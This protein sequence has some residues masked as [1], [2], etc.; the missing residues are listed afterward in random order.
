MDKNMFFMINDLIYDLYSCQSVTDLKNI[1]LPRLKLVIPCSYLTILLPTPP[2]HSAPFSPVYIPDSFAVA[3]ERYLQSL[4]E[5]QLLWN[6]YSREPKLVRESDLLPDDVRLNSHLYRECYQGFHIYDSLQYTSAYNRQ[7]L[8]V[9]TL[10]RTTDEPHFTED[11]MFFVNAIGLHFNA[12]LYRISSTDSQT[13]AFPPDASSFAAQ[14]HLTRKE[15]SIF[16]LLLLYKTNEEISDALKITINT[17]QKHIQNIFRKTN[18]TS[19][20]ELLRLF[21]EQN[22]SSHIDF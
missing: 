3:E 2:D 20:W 7:F 5:D 1:F 16:S 12:V 22:H 21:L 11:E 19:K 18:T 17:L 9:L 14:Y 13:N 15:T 8:G 4:H 6:C 10:F